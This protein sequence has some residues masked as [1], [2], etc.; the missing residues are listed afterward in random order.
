[1]IPIPESKTG[2]GKVQVKLQD[3]LEEFPAVTAADTQLATGAKVV[4]VAVVSGN[5]LEVKP[6]QEAVEANPEQLAT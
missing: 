4:V 3:R 1:M 2:Q 5:T 6:Q